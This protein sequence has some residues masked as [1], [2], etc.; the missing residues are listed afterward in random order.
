MFQRKLKFNELLQQTRSQVPIE[1]DL[2]SPVKT[3]ADGGIGRAVALLSR[4]RKPTLPYSNYLR[5]PTLARRNVLPN[6][7]EGPCS[8]RR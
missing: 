7:V 4:E 6:P 1:D 3:G 8:F 5:R 2:G